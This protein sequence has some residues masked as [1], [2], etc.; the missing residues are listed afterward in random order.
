MGNG[1][2]ASSPARARRTTAKRHSRPRKRPSHKRHV[3]LEISPTSTHNQQSHNGDGFA[4]RYRSNNRAWACSLMWCHW[5]SPGARS[6]LETRRLATS[7]LKFPCCFLVKLCCNA[8]HKPISSG[9]EDQPGHLRTAST[10]DARGTE[11]TLKPVTDRPYPPW[12]Q[13]SFICWASPN[14][15]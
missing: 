2:K 10:L 14:R 5:Q 3:R 15:T 9:V 12:R 13:H 4:Y 1:V 6:P 11:K 8:I 7:D